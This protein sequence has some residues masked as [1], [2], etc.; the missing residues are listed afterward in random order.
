M[1]QVRRLERFAKSQGWKDDEIVAE[2]GSGLNGKRK[3]R[4][5]VLRDPSIR[6]IIVEHRDRLARF[7][8]ERIEAAWEAAGKCVVVV[9]EG[10]VADDLTRDL[11]EILTSACG[12]WYGRRAARNRARRAIEVMGCK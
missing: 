12:R 4:L 5:R 9:E 8:F 7:G 11:I 2:I 1:R 3:K 6:H 10:E